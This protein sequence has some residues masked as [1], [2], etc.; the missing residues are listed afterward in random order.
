MSDDANSPDR[1]PLKRDKSERCDAP[2]GGVVTICRPYITTRD[3]RRIWAS[4]YGLKAFCFEV[5][6][7]EAS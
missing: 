7:E 4:Q 5:P 6:A 3:G 2:N 1:D